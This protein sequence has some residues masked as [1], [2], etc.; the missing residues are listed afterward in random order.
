M[1][2]TMKGIKEL[3]VQ[4]VCLRFFFF[5]KKTKLGGQLFKLCPKLK[6][7]HHEK[8]HVLLFKNQKQHHQKKDVVSN[9]SHSA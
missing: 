9:E 4:F 6:D 2:L 7:D 8:D 1:E 5:F 3:K